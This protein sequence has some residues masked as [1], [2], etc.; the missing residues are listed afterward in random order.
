L[1]LDDEN[2]V[3][4]GG[5]WGCVR[6]VE[7]MRVRT[8]HT[9]KT[10]QTDPK[11]IKTSFPLVNLQ[12]IKEKKRRQENSMRPYIN[13]VLGRKLSLTSPITAV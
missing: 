11:R 4:R 3:G 1:G 13:I 8:F 7:F 10:G 6:V 2:S 5:V 9:C 12:E